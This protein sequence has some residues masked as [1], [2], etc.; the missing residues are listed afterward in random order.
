MALYI[1]AMQVQGTS[2][3]QWHPL[4][5]AL[6]RTVRKAKENL[7]QYLLSPRFEQSSLE[8]CLHSQVPFPALWKNTLP[9]SMSR[10]EKSPEKT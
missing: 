8:F 6:V 7:R 5:L 4:N 10:A 3:P 9:F 1:G 2:L